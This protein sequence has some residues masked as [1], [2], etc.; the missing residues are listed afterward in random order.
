MRKKTKKKIAKIL[1]GLVALALI[2]TVSEFTSLKETLPCWSSIFGVNKSV[3]L[4]DG[5]LKMLFVDSGQ[6]DCT[7][8]R[9]K[10]NTIVI[11]AGNI[12]DKE[13]IVSKL[14]KENVETIDAFI[15]SHPHADHI[16]AAKEVIDNFDIKS[17][18]MPDIPEK[19]IPTSKTF[20]NLIDAVADKGLSFTEA[21]D[22]L[23]LEFGD[24]K[25]DFLAPSKEYDDLNNVSAVV[26][27]TYGNKSFLFCGDAEKESEDDI[28]AKYP[29]INADLIKVG[30][31]GSR[32]S[33]SANFLKSVDPE[34]AI[35]LV[36][37]E[38]EYGHPAADIISRFESRGAKIYRSDKHGDI[39]I[40]C[41]GNNIEI[42]TEKQ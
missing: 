9:T 11:D 21:K 28:T 12:D 14:K 40:L 22:G 41:D 25:L 7:I 32:S 42:K 24:M 19:I 20:E 27:I 8:I 6:S 38:N 29:R 18:Y 31:H 10:S 1:Y 26:K 4:N 17:I 37:A 30:H 2:L 35:V 5:E 3:T 16:G 15:I 34:I 23:K 39:T 13:L 36:G 33:S